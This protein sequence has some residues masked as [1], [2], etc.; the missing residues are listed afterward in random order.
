MHYPCNY[1][2]IPHTIAGDDDP[3]DVL[4]VTQFALPPGV[5]VRCRPIGMLAMEDEAGQDGKLLAVPVDSLTQM[6]RD[7]ESPRDFP[8]VI[9]DQIAHFFAHY[10]DLERGKWVKVAGWLG[11]D[12]AK[13]EIMEGVQR[14]NDAKDK[15][16]Y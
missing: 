12:E 2:Y 7:I 10:K 11:V 3:V 16:N 13:K 14:F 8:Q 6:Y 9:L 15:P 5:V 4:V 1:G